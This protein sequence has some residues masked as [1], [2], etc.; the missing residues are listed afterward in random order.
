MIGRQH[1]RLDEEW[2]L[3]VARTLV[4]YYLLFLG[5]NVFAQSC[6]DDVK[7]D[8]EWSELHWMSGSR[9]NTY[10]LPLPHSGDSVAITFQIRSLHPGYFK[11]AS[12]ITPFIDGGE[13]QHF[14]TSDD[15]G[16]LFTGADE[17]DANIVEV[18]AYFSKPLS[19]VSFDI[20]DIDIAG[21][22][23]DEVIVFGNDSTI[24]PTLKVLG[25]DP[26]VSVERNR[27]LAKGTGSGRSRT[28]ASYGGDDAGS[29]HVD[30]STSYIDSV[31]IYYLDNDPN[32]QSGGRGIGLFGNFQYGGTNLRPMDLVTFEVERDDA[33]KPIIK[34]MTVHEHG[35]EEYILEYSYDGFNFAEA[36]RWHADNSYTDTVKYEKS[37]DRKLNEENYFRLIKVSNDEAAQMLALSSV[38]GSCYNLSAVNIYPNPSHRDFFYAEIDAKSARI[39]DVIVIDQSGKPV[40][41]TQYELK[42]GKNWFKINSRYFAPGVYHVRFVVDEEIVT[43]MISIMS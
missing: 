12:L 25:E 26:V 29:V 20:S 37:L 6:P 36:A 41:K 10:R 39:A 7:L 22:H 19:C 2:V 35:V 8:M 28:G 23:R 16:I 42:E 3:W 38:E 34:W 5:S 4:I 31:T 43:R 24:L 14:G 33:C 17:K 27:A 15:V 18:K 40:M 1:R 11:T 13:G 9:Y 21:H 32:P 30:F